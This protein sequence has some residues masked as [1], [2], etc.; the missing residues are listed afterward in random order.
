MFN[1]Y[2]SQKYFFL[3]LFYRRHNRISLEM[4]RLQERLWSSNSFNSTY[5]WTFPIENIRFICWEWYQM[6]DLQIPRRQYHP[7]NQTCGFTAWK[8][9]WIYSHR[10]IFFNKFMF[11]IFLLF[12]IFDSFIF[13]FWYFSLF[14]V[15]FFFFYFLSNFTDFTDFSPFWIFSPIFQYLQFFSHFF[16]HDFF[17]FF[18]TL[19]LILI[20]FLFF[21]RRRSS[22]IHYWTRNR[23]KNAQKIN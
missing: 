17:T 22:P 7:I 21:F 23:R 12:S 2:F 11:W 13:S 9:S 1:F 15:F 5:S 6:Q 10:Y 20:F 16:F 4:L 8:N 3:Y 18:I 19:F 14:H